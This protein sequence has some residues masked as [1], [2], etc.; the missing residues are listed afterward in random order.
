MVLFFSSRENNTI[1][2]NDI[3]IMFYSLLIGI[4]FG[5]L[6]G[7][8]SHEFLLESKATMSNGIFIQIICFLYM[9]TGLAEAYSKVWVCVGG[10]GRTS[11]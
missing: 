2:T 7:N 11:Y 10:E 5:L 3:H 1:G 6:G 8:Y 4:G 9:I